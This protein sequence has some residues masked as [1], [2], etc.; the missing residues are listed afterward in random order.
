MSASEAA[1][2]IL[3]ESQQRQISHGKFQSLDDDSGKSKYC[4]WPARAQAD[5]VQ[6]P[7]F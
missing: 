3:F 7:A 2:F 5:A 4:N 6:S 1:V